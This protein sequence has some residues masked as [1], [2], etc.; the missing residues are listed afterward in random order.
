MQFLEVD[1]SLRVQNL[2]CG[3]GAQFWPVFLRVFFLYFFG[4]V[5]FQPRAAAIDPLSIQNSWGSFRFWPEPKVVGDDDM[6]RRP[7]IY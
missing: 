7:G 5:I 4:E 6:A 1:F 3:I 2:F